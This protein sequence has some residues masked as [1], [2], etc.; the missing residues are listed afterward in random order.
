MVAYLPVRTKELS[1]I[2]FSSAVEELYVE[3][4]PPIS[5]VD[6][7][8]ITPR[9]LRVYRNFASP[10]SFVRACTKIAL[11]AFLRSLCGASTFLSGRVSSTINVLPPLS[12][13][14][15]IGFWRHSMSSRYLFFQSRI[16]RA[17]TFS[18]YCSNG[19][20]VH[21]V[22]YFSYTRL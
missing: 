21:F 13:P 3:L 22:V 9:T 18:S 5:E 14:V 4:S 2:M 6:R 17:A 12:V 19:F 11:S 15:S 16:I 10:I 20:W 8:V 7:A 1:S